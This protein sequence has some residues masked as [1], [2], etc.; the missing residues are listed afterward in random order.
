MLMLKL[1]LESNILVLLWGISF[2]KL[3]GNLENLKRKK[4]SEG[5][6]KARN[7]TKQKNRWKQKLS[8][9]FEYIK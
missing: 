9:R 7:D 3:L 4:K 5:E 6:D 8:I 2:I 1:H